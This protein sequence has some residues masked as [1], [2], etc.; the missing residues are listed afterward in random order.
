M[1]EIFQEGKNKS[2]NSI[3]VLNMHIARLEINFI[4]K[5]EV[6]TKKIDSCGENVVI[7]NFGNFTLGGNLHVNMH[8]L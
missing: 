4:L 2:K 7:S 8:L 6:D 3:Q 5:N 1:S